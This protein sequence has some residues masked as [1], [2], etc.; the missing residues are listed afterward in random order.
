[1]AFLGEKRLGRARGGIILAVL[2]S[3]GITGITGMGISSASASEADTIGSLL[4]QAR[5]SAGLPPLA[6][7][8]AMDAVA[9]RWAQQMAANGAMSHNPSY[10]S[11]IPR[12][13]SSAGENVATGF[14]SASETHT[15]W[16][17]SPGHRANILG[18]Y[19]S[20]GV[21]YFVDANGVSWAV[22][23]FGKYGAAAAAPAP[24]PAA[25]AAAPAHAPAA[26]AAPVRRAAPAAPAAAAPAAVPAA[27]AA[28]PPPPP[29]ITPQP[30]APPSPAQKMD[31]T[32]SALRMPGFSATASASAWTKYLSPKIHLADSTRPLSSDGP[33]PLILVVVILGLL[34][35]IVR[36]FAT[37]RKTP[38]SR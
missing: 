27:P 33:I 22:E 25:R 1:M 8:G 23:D 30:T 38:S 29:V 31:G 32:A 7:N 35:F 11:Q 26:K 13:W 34:A 15:A 16:M 37:F 17:N 20:V 24:A 14:A 18:D 3:I 4:N 2:L 21:A 9:A 5:A 6:R 12:G 19:T 28:P 36:I 10:S